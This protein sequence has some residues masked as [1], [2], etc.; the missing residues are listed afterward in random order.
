MISLNVDPRPCVTSLH[1]EDEFNMSYFP[2][3]YIVLK[4]LCTFILITCVVEIQ[5]T[6]DYFDGKLLKA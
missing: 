6:F 3:I 4:M 2:A 5:W 1:T